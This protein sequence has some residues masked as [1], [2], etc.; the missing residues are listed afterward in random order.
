MRRR[1]TAQ[2]YD[3]EFL[4]APG[5]AYHTPAL[6]QRHR[7]PK[8][9][10]PL[11]T[12]EDS[13]NASPSSSTDGGYGALER[14]I[15]SEFIPSSQPSTSRR[16]R[17]K[18]HKIPSTDFYPSRDE[19]HTNN[20]YLKEESDSESARIRV[21]EEMY[22]AMKQIKKFKA[23]ISEAVGKY[24]QIKIDY[25][26]LLKEHHSLAF[27]LIEKDHKIQ[28]LE[29]EIAQLSQ[30]KRSLEI[31]NQS[32]KS[33][34][35]PYA[36]AAA[37]QHR[38]HHHYP[39][40]Y[41]QMPQA[42]HYSYMTPPSQIR[43][44]QFNNTN[45]GSLMASGGERSNSNRIPLHQHQR[46]GVENFFGNINEGSGEQLAF[47]SANTT[48]S[49][50]VLPGIPNTA[51]VTDEF[52]DE[53][54]VF[55]KMDESSPSR[56]PTN[57]NPSLILSTGMGGSNSTGSSPPNNNKTNEQTPV[58]SIK[59]ESSPKASDPK[60]DAY[61]EIILK[62]LNSLTPKSS[63]IKKTKSLS[64]MDDIAV[65]FETAPTDLNQ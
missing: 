39:P 17:S 47:L 46:H 62:Q 36:A 29:S 2:T 26:K 57:S 7:G 21:E 42:S 61:N 22:N 60:I 11:R 53:V 1:N 51:N 59:K 14:S 54:K 44:S 45:T 18:K 37:S 10:P 56:P 41:P 20:R 31:E 30:E 4:R 32:L 5:A 23:G 58:A 13:P 55:R 63:K 27:S 6:P 28:Q 9:L 16:S 40:A 24:R 64:T 49:Q 48:A 65:N 43:S 25:D 52:R 15:H 3:D 34:G 38:Y 19:R 12:F 50:P 8:S 35:Y 33:M